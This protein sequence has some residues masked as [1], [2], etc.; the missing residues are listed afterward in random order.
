[1]VRQL[2]ADFAANGMDLAEQRYNSFFASL[3]ERFKE[4]QPDGIKVG[5]KPFSFSFSRDAFPTGREQFRQALRGQL[6]TAFDLVN[7]VLLPAA[8]GHLKEAGFDDILLVVDDLDKIPQKVL[9]DHGVTNHEQLFLDS[10]RTLRALNVSLLL[11]V[12]IELAYSPLQGRLRDDYGASI[13]TVPLIAIVDRAGERIPEGEDALI[14]II[15]RR[16]R[17]AVGGGDHDPAACA[18]KIFADEELLRR[19]VALSGG[20]LRGL[21]VMLTELLDWVD[22]LPIESEAVERYVLRS[23]KDLARA[24][25]PSDKEILHRVEETK[26]AVED[27]RFFTLL[28]SRYV[29][30]YESGR[31][32][33][34]YGLNPLLQVGAL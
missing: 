5:V 29:L 19:V 9:T 25:L 13:A 18:R 6:P 17:Q 30:A 2:A 34:W 3:W 4:M 33:S 26:E 27:T 16:V 31:E 32:E 12:P 8:R 11:T 22:Q 10:S 15:G 7:Q 20:H 24:L 28:Q 1:M 14:E 21:L 23:A